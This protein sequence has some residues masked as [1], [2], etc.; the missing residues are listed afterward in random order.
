MVFGVAPLSINQFGFAGQPFSWLDNPE[1]GLVLVRAYN[2][3]LFEDIVGNYPD[4]FISCQLTWFRDVEVAAQEILKNADRGF[5]S[6]IFTENPEK[7]GFPTIHSGYWD[8]FFAAC[9]ETGTIINIHLG[10][11]SEVIKPSSGFTTPNNSTVHLRQ[12]NTGVP[13]LGVFTITDPLPGFE[14]RLLGGRD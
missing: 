6:V 9:Q 11:S 14:S 7:I 13:G 1:E 4:R 8:P 10:S 5:K 2:D 12:S 3:W